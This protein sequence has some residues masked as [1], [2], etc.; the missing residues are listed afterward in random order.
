MPETPDRQPAE[1]PAGLGLGA[2]VPAPLR[3]AVAAALRWVEEIDRGA[4]LSQAP[5]RDRI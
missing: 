4:A 2:D 1:L 5:P 3:A